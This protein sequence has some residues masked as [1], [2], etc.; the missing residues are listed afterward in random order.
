[1]TKTIPDAPEENEVPPRPVTSA[2]EPARDLVT[3]YSRLVH[4]LENAS[5]KKGACGRDALAARLAEL[6][7]KGGKGPAQPTAAAFSRAFRRLGFA[8]GGTGIDRFAEELAKN[9]GLAVTRPADHVLNLLAMFCA[10]DDALSLKPVCGATP[11]CPE[12]LLTRECDHYNKP[13]TPAV[14]LIPPAARLLSGYDKALSDAE[15]L[16][17]LLYGEKATGQEAV[18]ATLLDRYGPLR[19]I[20]R[21]EMQEYL[22][23]RDMGRPQALRLAAVNAIHRRVLAEKRT[24]VPRITSAKDIHDRYAA[25]LRDY[26]SEA[27]VVLF[28]D[29]QNSVIRD[30]WF[31]DN[32]PNA[33]YLNLADLLRPAIREYAVRIALVHNHPSNNP[34]PS[35]EDV[36]FT[37]RLRAACDIV[38]IGLVDHVIVTEYGYY[39]FSENGGLSI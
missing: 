33:A 18:V 15:L 35:P 14:A 22:G 37:R 28:L 36:E 11:L 32:S 6:R 21:A 7:Q 13:R 31:C 30:A 24:E 19:A 25:E 12:C 2:P 20:F 27:A 10:G 4:T 8:A 34:A 38:G 3:F 39:S 9:I 1:M 26:Q 5:E 16:G 29:Q 23:V 17:V